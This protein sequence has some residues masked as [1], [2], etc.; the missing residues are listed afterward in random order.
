M[1]KVTRKSFTMGIHS[2]TKNKREEKKKF[3]LLM[4]SSVPKDEYMGCIYSLMVDV[5]ITMVSDVG[6]YSFSQKQAQKRV[7]KTFSWLVNFSSYPVD[8]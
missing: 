7:L 5:K 1:L 4:K 8:I 6:F 2:S 3:G